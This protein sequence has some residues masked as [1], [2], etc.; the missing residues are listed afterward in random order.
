VAG[1]LVEGRTENNGGY[2]AVAGIGINANQRSE[3]F[4]EEL[5][6]TAGSLAQAT[7]RAIDRGKL[8][9]ALLRTLEKGI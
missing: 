1:I 9:V 2:V 7:G 8:A 3:D 5:R 4:P 6:A